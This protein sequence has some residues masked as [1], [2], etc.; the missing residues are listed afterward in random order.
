MDDWVTLDEGEYYVER[1]LVLA[2]DGSATSLWEP[3]LEVFRDPTGRRR[4]VVRAL[5]FS[6]ELVAIME[7]SDQLDVLLDLGGDFTYRLP[8]PFISAGKIFSPGVR[9]AVQVTPSGPWK[10]LKRERYDSELASV[11]WVANHSA[12]R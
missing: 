7:N 3:Y 8:T 5:A 12:D 9:S 4:L 11:R 6:L 10:R 1:A 2:P